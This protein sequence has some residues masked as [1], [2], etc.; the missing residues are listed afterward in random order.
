DEDTRRAVAL[1]AVRAAVEIDSQYDELALKQRRHGSQVMIALEANAAGGPD[2]PSAPAL[3][4]YA[5]A[6]GRVADRLSSEDALPSPATVLR[7]LRAVSAP[8]GVAEALDERRLVQLAA[9][10]SKDAAA[11]ARLE[12]YPRDLPPHRALRLAQA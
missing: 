1:A 3:L 12:V 5:D 10:A 2:T 6:L 9:A 11:N 4:D 7:A 8:S